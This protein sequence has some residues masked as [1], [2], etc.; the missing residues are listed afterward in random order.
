MTRASNS[1]SGGSL[2]AKRRAAAVERAARDH[3]PPADDR[4]AAIH[5][6]LVRPTVPANI[7]AAVR[8]AKAMD[9]GA[10]RLVAPHA[11]VN[12]A[13][14]SLAA[15]AVAELRRV[16]SF[17]ALSDAIKG[18]VRVYGLSARRHEHRTAPIWLDEAAA[19]AVSL[20]A[21]GTVL[22]LFGTE[23][24]G[25]ENEELD[26]AQRIV[27]IKT[28]SRFM[29]LNLAQAVMVVAYELKRAA[30]A[31]LEPYPYVPAT[32]DE[33]ERCVE[34]LARSLDRRDFF[35]S[36]KRTLAVRRIRDMLG[37][38]APNKNEI[39]LLRGMIRALDED[40][41]EEAE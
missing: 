27:R 24:T 36:S 15:G 31:E 6:V 8:A 40:E 19:E 10:I 17:P 23:R 14:E 12:E 21:R 2:A 3:R 34:A 38:A 39:S 13:A 4:L 37:R 9:L 5:P 26:H 28:S 1:G 35:I 20:A 11:P 32:A 18:A 22:F 16:R 41:P 7:G 25:L 29:S 33:I 30:G